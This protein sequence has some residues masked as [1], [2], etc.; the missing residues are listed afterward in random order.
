LFTEAVA[1]LFEMRQQLCLAWL[2]EEALI[3]PLGAAG[4]IREYPNIA[5][6]KWFSPLENHGKKAS[7][8]DLFIRVHGILEEDASE[9]DTLRDVVMIESKIGSREKKGSSDATRSILPICRIS[10]AR[11]SSI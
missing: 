8:V 3:N 1:H 6:Q 9:G 2:E 11:R 5:T 4:F 7:Q 10:V